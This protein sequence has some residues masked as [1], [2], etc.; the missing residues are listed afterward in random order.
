MHPALPSA[1][2]ICSTLISSHNFYHPLLGF[3]SS[4]SSSSSASLLSSSLLSSFQ[5]F[6]PPLLRFIIKPNSLE[7]LHLLHN[8]ASPPPTTFSSFSIST[9]YFSTF[10]S[11][12]AFSTFFS[13]TPAELSIML[14][15]P[16]VC[17][18]L[19]TN[20]SP[21]SSPPSL[22]RC[23]NRRS[24]PSHCTHQLQQRHDKEI[25]K[26]LNHKHCVMNDH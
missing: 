17:S 14:A 13:L 11:T 6:S 7:P 26:R 3:S 20:N 5:L 8:T 22:F 16:S 1:S 19:T 18:M 24:S 15:D 21:F 2:S 4:S 25:Q 9:F 23:I 12:F 10:S